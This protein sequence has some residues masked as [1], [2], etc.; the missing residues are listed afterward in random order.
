MEEIDN[1]PDPRIYGIDVE[2]LNLNVLLFLTNPERPHPLHQYEQYMRHVDPVRME[3]QVTVDWAWNV[4]HTEAEKHKSTPSLLS[5]PTLI[6]KYLPSFLSTDLH[7]CF[8][9]NHDCDGRICTS[10]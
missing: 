2:L 5:E 7:Q 9:S 10:N 4:L 6:L 3:Y 8:A 1:L